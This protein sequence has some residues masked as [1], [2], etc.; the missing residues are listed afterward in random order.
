MGLRSALARL[1]AGA[2]TPAF[3]VAGAGGRWAAEQL[4]LEPRIAPTLSPRAADALVVVGYLSEGLLPAVML[5]HDQIPPPRLAFQWLPDGAPDDP[6]AA[7]V[8]GVRVVEGGS[9]VEVVRDAHAG[10][11]AGRGDGH[12]DAWPDVEPAPWRGI[13]P[14]GQGGKGMTGGV[15][16][17][18]PLTGR[19]D[20][21]DGLKL[22]R[23]DV[24]VGPLFPAFPPGLELIVGLQ[25]D[26]AEEVSVGENPFEGALEDDVFRRALREAVPIAELEV[27]RAR[28]HLRWLAGALRVAGLPSLGQRVLSL[29]VR[30]KPEDADWV[31][32]LGR[33]LARGRGLRWLAGA[34][35]VLREDLGGP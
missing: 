23:L 20:D 26:V 14:Y 13:G 9:L 12:E 30:A 29:A 16:Y 34:V 11:L 32:R 18:R 21:R 17:G 19:A 15:P 7:M 35:G 8:P 10:L 5:A 24:R 28:S 27:A 6:L 22:D 4:W 1:A 31:S 2:P 33:S 25:G 3:V